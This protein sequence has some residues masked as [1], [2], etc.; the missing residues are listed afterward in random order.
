M[1]TNQTIIDST[2]QQVTDGSDSAWIQITGGVVY[3]A[4][5]ETMPERGAAAHTLLVGEKINAGPPLK[6]WIRSG[7]DSNAT[8]V[9]T[10]WE[11]S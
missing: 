5:A 3:L 8:A 6:I 1:P 9:I 4:D 11:Q 10:K 2:W 7:P